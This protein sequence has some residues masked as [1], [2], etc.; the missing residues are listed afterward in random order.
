VNLVIGYL[1]IFGWGV[2]PGFEVAGAGWS[3]TL[4]RM[5]IVVTAVV[6]MH[7]GR[8]LRDLAL[9]VRRCGLASR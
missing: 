7:R 3:G 6:V 4:V 9:A 2:L 1:A 5:L 8:A